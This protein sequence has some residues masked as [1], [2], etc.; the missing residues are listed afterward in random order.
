MIAHTDGALLVDR[1]DAPRYVRLNDIRFR[2]TEESREKLNVDQANSAELVDYA[3]VYDSGVYTFGSGFYGEDVNGTAAAWYQARKDYGFADYRIDG[4][5][6]PE[7]QMPSNFMMFDGWTI[8]TRAGSP[9]ELN[10]TH[11][12]AIETHWEI[13]VNSGKFGGYN[14][15]SPD[16]L[17]YDGTIAGNKFTGTV[18]TPVGGADI[19]GHFFGPSGHEIAG[20][21]KNGGANVMFYGAY[22]ESLTKSKRAA[23]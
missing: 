1:A 13:D 7:R 5:L 23:Q 16:V 18:T 2:L 19:E 6:T 22:D 8:A 3:D 15:V 20:G 9:S 17:K 11:N 21:G 4:N 12:L 14:P 10:G